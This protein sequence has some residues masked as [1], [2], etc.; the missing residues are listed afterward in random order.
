MARRIDQRR[1]AS[2]IRAAQRAVW[3]AVVARFRALEARDGLRQADLAH[4]LGVSRPQIHEW[5][6]DPAN[7]TLKAAA[8]LMLAMDGSPRW[9]LEDDG[10]SGGDHPPPAA[11][12]LLCGPAGW[13]AQDVL[14]RICAIASA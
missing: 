13:F 7:M 9:R 11:W 6:S 3:R 14:G 8:R 1:Q 5:L 10:P 4:R 2:A 12:V